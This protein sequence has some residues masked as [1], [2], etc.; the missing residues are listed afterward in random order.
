MASWLASARRAI[1]PQHWLNARCPHCRAHALLA[2]Y[3]GKL[4]IGDIDGAPGPCFMVD[5][6]TRV[7]GLGYSVSKDRLRVCLGDQEWL[8]KLA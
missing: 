8:I 1:L 5:S 4:E 2:L 7:P 3:K 6:S